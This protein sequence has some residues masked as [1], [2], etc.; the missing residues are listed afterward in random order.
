LTEVN[1]TSQA[2]QP[3]VLAGIRRNYSRSRFEKANRAKTTAKKQA[4]TRNQFQ[5]AH[6]V[7]ACWSDSGDSFNGF[8]N[9][10]VFRG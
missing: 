7:A 1:L 8:V 3:G 2:L 5:N 4:K 10:N 6:S 9:K